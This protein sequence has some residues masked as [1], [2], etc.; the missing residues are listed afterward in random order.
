MKG[1]SKARVKTKAT[2]YAVVVIPI[3]LPNRIV[4]VVVYI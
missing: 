4:V 2:A 1:T 3:T